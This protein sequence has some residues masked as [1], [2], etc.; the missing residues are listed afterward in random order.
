[1]ELVRLVHL[2]DIVFRLINQSAIVEEF[3]LLGIL[4][5]AEIPQRM[6]AQFLG[7]AQVQTLLGDVRLGFLG[8][9]VHPLNSAGQKQ[10]RGGNLRS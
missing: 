1:M 10:R 3:R 7:V 9:Q 8:G 5:V 6:L 4:N 2:L